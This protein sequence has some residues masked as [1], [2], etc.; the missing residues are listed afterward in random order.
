MQTPQA[1]VICWTMLIQLDARRLLLIPMSNAS[2]DLIEVP[3]STLSLLRTVIETEWYESDKR[4]VVSGL[5]VWNE[6]Q[7]STFMMPD[8]SISGTL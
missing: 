6:L 1:T 8:S 7:S 4:S 3:T 2:A 5:C